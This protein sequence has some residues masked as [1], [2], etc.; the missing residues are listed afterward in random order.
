[1]AE[2]HDKEWGEQVQEDE[3]FFERLTLEIF[4]AGLNWRMILN[5]R[6]ALSRAFNNFSVGRVDKFNEQ[7]IERLLDDSSIIRN[8]RKIEATI[9]NAAVFLNIQRTYGSFH[10]FLAAHNG[11]RQEIIER[12][13]S[14]FFF[15][16]PTVTE[17][18]LMSVGKFSPHHDPDC[19][20]VS[21]EPY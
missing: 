20:K 16:G 10:T 5:K 2:Y 1:M 14:H 19:W 11:N 21:S 13:S 6:L 3:I 15:T 17:W 7:D 18:F 8:R 4:Q 12:I 9:K